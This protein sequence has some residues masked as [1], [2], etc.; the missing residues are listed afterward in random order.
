MSNVSNLMSQI[1]AVACAIIEHEGKVLA[2][3][4]GAAMSQPL[5][6]EFP[7]GKVEPGESLEGCIAREI[8]EE[9]GVA[10]AVGQRLPDNVHDYGN[11]KVIRLVPFRCRL[12]SH[13]FALKEHEQV[14]W[15]TPAEL[16]GLDWA[17]ADVP[18]V[19]HYLSRREG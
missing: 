5:Q 18:I 16:P 11:G 4:R 14:R 19:Q 12:L 10:V 7:G 2:A 17:P 9:L 8:R 1:I 13:A 15:L 3:R 6:W